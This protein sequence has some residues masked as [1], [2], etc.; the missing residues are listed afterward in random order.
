L[1]CAQAKSRQFWLV[2][3]MHPYYQMNRSRLA[4]GSAGVER[5]LPNKP[6]KLTAA[7]FSQSCGFSRHGSW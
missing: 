5:M 3:Q 2:A 7:G 4:G 1:T 6:L